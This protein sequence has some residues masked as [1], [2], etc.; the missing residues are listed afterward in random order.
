VKDV[1][2]MAVDEVGDSGDFAFA[3]RA[4][5]EEDGAIFHCWL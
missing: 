2:T 1:A 4:G 3:V 5:D